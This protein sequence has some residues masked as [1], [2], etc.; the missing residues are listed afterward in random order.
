MPSQRLLQAPWL[1]PVALLLLEPRSRGELAAKLGISSKLAK[2]VLYA[3]CRKGLVVR[4]ADGKYKLVSPK[5]ISG[6][7]VIAVH[8]NAMVFRVGEEIYV[9]RIR[10]KGFRCFTVRHE[11][12]AEA[13]NSIALG[14]SVRDFARKKCI[15]LGI[16]K[17]AYAAARAILAPSLRTPLSS[18]ALQSVHLY[19]QRS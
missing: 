12:V 3:L 1:V 13:M 15:A 19:S 5:I 17:K 18:R 4:E 8:R 14:D 6:I 9:V 7:E 10:K 16:A 11:L 2:T